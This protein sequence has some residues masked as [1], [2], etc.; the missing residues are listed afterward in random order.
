MF[1]NDLSVL[2]KYRY[3]LKVKMLRRS[4]GLCTAVR[5]NAIA[6]PLVRRL[7]GG[8]HGH[9]HGTGSSHGPAVPYAPYHAPSIYGDVAH[10]FGIAPGT[11][12]EG[13]ENVTYLTYFLM[14]GMFIYGIFIA[15]NES[16]LVR[17][18]KT[19]TDFFF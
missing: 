7:G 4:L 6:A 16:P 1:A 11:P 14:T 19:N 3:F 15:D 17:I 12:K 2:V 10:P 8:G 13:W 18:D 5:R 9:G